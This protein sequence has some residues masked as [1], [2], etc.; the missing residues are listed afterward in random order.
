[1]SDFIVNLIGS[2][3]ANEVQRQLDLMTLLLQEP[4]FVLMILLGGSI[5]IIGFVGCSNLLV[6]CFMKDWDLIMVNIIMMICGSIITLILFL[7]A[8]TGNVLIFGIMM[9]MF[10]LA[11]TQIMIWITTQKPK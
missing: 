5:L 1:M 6:S 9:F 7:S 3:V 11:W 8:L 4:M 2:V 10:A